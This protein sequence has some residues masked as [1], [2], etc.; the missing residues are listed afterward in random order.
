MDLSPDEIAF[1][2]SV[3]NT[4]YPILPLPR[5]SL[6]RLEEVRLIKF[7]KHGWPQL[8]RAGRRVIKKEELNFRRAA[9]F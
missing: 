6:Q 2:W 4:S 9:G 3:K 7:D 5:E 1:L 8:T